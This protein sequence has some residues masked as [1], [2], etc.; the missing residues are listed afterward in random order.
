MNTESHWLRLQELFHA[1][2]ELEPDAR[3]AYV[4]EQAGDDP[5]LL[6]ELLKM[7][8]IEGSATARLQTPMQSA[9]ALMATDMKIMP[10]TRFG[11][12]EVVRAIGH[13]GMGQVYL[14]RRADGTFQREVALKLI[15]R[16]GLDTRQLVLF[17]V[18][19]Q[20]LG[21]MNHPA[22]AQIHDAGTDEHGRPWLVMEYIEGSP[23]TTFCEQHALSLRRRIELF[24]QVCRGVQHAHLQG[25][26]HRDI[27]PDNVL[28]RDINEVP[29]PC[30]I[31]FGI[32]AGAGNAAIPAGTR[33]YMSPEQIDPKARVD[34][35]SDIY[36]LGAL[37]YELIS[38]DRPPK[39]DSS[40]L[41]HIPSQ[42]LA[43]L[44]PDKVQSLAEQRGLPPAKLLRTLREDLDWIVA[45]AMHTDP[46]QRYQSADLLIDDLSRFLDGQVVGAAPPRRGV[47]V[48][49]FIR[50]H[51][52]G[53]A[54]ASVLVLTLIG[55]LAATSW[56][57]QQARTEAHRKQ[58]TTNFLSGILSS[59]DPALA[60]DLDKTL[61]LKVLD[62]AAERIDT[63][64]ADDPQ[65]RVDMHMAMARS[66][67]SIG[68]VEKAAPQV[69]QARAVL[70]GQGL[71]GSAQ[72]VVLVKRLGDMYGI[73]GKIHE[74]EQALREVITLATALG[75]KAPATLIPE[76]RSLLAYALLEQGQL[77][78]AL[79]QAQAGYD[80]LRALL[81]ENDSLV[82]TA[83]ERLSAL[84]SESGQSERATALLHSLI[85]TRAEEFGRDH[86]HVLAMR[87]TLATLFLR[88]DQPTEAEAELRSLLGPMTRQHGEES[89]LVASA[90][91]RLGGAL[92]EQGKV[93][94]AGPHYRF[95]LDY[96]VRAQ[97]PESPYATIM[98]HSYATWLLADGQAEQA[99]EEL[100]VCRE[101]GEKLYGPR[102][103]FMQEVWI[104]LGQTHLALGNLQEARSSLEQS[105]A[106][107]IELYG[108][109]AEFPK[110]LQQALRQLDIDEAASE[111]S[112]SPAAVIL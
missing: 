77:D 13:G 49:K 23:I 60:R 68:N 50:R 64:L 72:D 100:T 90:H 109:E 89:S 42:R 25:V 45:K 34:S 30:L 41:E 70:A 98:R 52:L 59:A 21:Q 103:P 12:W 83:G 17:E 22:I 31:D 57:L 9:Q 107:Q 32:A 111:H 37:L 67:Y 8:A 56:A 79:E 108:A 104:T 33:G 48:R 36:S 51:R 62:A 105:R 4:R 75:P 97:G 80:G 38:G 5:E 73:L 14:A 82:I 20:M 11:P 61:I 78:E 93:E 10:G 94:E 112:D 46:G 58:V 6:H 19:R 26:V 88:N 96:Y 1:A 106:I 74:S 3:D 84:L 95:A 69:E 65:G 81:P 66:F 55:G 35:R 29:T 101:L 24:Q 39:S 47:A 43:T 16:V 85:D 87:L 44:D 102:S 7:L 18:E 15:G 76:A 27:K 92:L 86:P 40:E 110:D 53:V 54:T 28:V 63:E 2:C 91:Q 71:S 99:L